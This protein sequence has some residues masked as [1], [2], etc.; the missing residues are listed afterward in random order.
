[1]SLRYSIE[2]ESRECKN[3]THNLC[4]HRWHGL[5]MYVHC[6]CYCHKK[7]GELENSFQGD[8]NSDIHSPLQEEP[9]SD[10]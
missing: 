10:G 3:C 4:M 1:M 2:F 8:S 5:G 7:R 9:D 6:S